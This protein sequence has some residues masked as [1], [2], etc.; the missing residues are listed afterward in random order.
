[1]ADDDVM[2]MM[3]MMM[4]MVLCFSFTFHFLGFPF[5]FSSF[6]SGGGGRRGNVCERFTESEAYHARYCRTEFFITPL[7]WYSSW[8]FSSVIDVESHAAY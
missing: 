4:M 8:E 1:M 5:G 3:M 2:M 7:A 6:F